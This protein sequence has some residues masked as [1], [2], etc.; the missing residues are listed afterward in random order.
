[1]KRRELASILSAHADGLI[2][3]DDRSDQFLLDFPEAAA[4]LRP[5][6]NLAASIQ[7]VLVPVKAPVAFVNRLRHDL[8]NYSGPEISVKGPLSGQRILWM[9]V[10]AAGSVL[11]VTGLAL[12]VWR[13]LKSSGETGQQTATAV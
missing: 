11:S 7:A 8:M 2:S 10:A 3:G 9:G 1:M 4:E 13:R 5:L 6:F 12:W